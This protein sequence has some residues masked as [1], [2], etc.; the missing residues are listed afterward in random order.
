[1][2]SD[3]RTPGVGGLGPLARETDDLLLLVGALGIVPLLWRLL[4]GWTPGASVSGFDAMATIIPVLSELV[5]AGGDWSA[6][7][8]R[9]ELLGGMKVRDAIGPFPLFSWLASLGLGTTA[10]YNVSAFVVQALIG[11][12]GVRAASDLATAWGGRMGWMTRLIGLVLVAF[13]PALGW[14]VG[15]GH[16][17]LVVG[18][19]PFMAG[20][21][22]LAAACAGTVTIL[23]ALTAL[24][25]LYCGI[26][27]TG[28]QVVLYGAVFGA[29]ILIGLWWSLGS[30]PRALAI[31]L[32]V[33]LV[34][35]LLALP[36]FLPVLAHARSSDSP[37]A[38]GRT[39]ITYSYLT[40]R[41]VD[42]L[43]SVL[44]TRAAIP[45]GQPELHHHETN[46]PLG[47]VLVLA[48]LVPW[49]RARALGWG[50]AA[51]ALLA[52]LFA[53]NARPVSTAL[54]ALIP[55]LNSFRVPTRALL[56][57]V[58]VLPVL[59]TAA[60]ALRAE[61]PSRRTLLASVAMVALFWLPAW[62][63]EVLGWGLAAALVARHGR[64]ITPQLP[65]IAVACAVAAGGLAAFRDRL[66]PM[67]LA[68]RSL[69]AM[70]EMGRR[71]KALRPEL[72]SPLNRVSL[73]FEAPDFGPNT[74]FASGLSALDGYYFPSRRYIELFCALHKYE[75]QPNALLLRF[76]ASEAW[77]RP[78]FALY[79]VGWFLERTEASQLTGRRLAPTA[80]PAWFSQG[81][82]P[83]P[84]FAALGRVLLDA[85]SD[86]ATRAHQRLW[87]V[88]SDPALP[89]TLPRQVDPAC[90]SARV[91]SAAATPGRNG[92][93][94]TL[95][96]PA[97]C[98]LAIAMD[99]V[100]TL[101]A[102]ATDASGSAR[103]AMLFPACGSLTGVWVP[104]G[105]RDLLVEAR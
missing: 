91:V 61:A 37:R 79:N 1:M 6:L 78:A 53:M 82:E 58:M 32:L 87:I 39:Q 43:A 16:L 68:D 63:R 85:G 18:L 97:D 7:V 49:R 95:E 62:P 35:V 3:G 47:P 93:R 72:Q 74:A 70:Q 12:L 77:T 51:S 56:P 89:A 33:G 102:H 69:Q 90:A 9:P 17:T 42:W 98:P 83:V 45:G 30:R 64:P 41:P 92:V 66:L 26:L 76:P 46:V 52:L 29:P 20:L 86:V 75:Y 34:A 28:H 40:Q 65:V 23:L 10:V 67:P 4:L 80:G 11:F 71:L 99:F 104:A 5:A 48:A 84:S 60:V 13:V 27:F 44:W 19:L 73:G 105:T 50:A 88:S 14:R 31:P 54:L 24:L 81:L 101:E 100:E 25:A 103:R 55:P 15:Y 38:L 57:F 96:T 36:S 21:A 2:S 59:A 8:Y 94:L 22:I